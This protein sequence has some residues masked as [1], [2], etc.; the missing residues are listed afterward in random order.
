MQDFVHH[1]ND[2]AFL[3]LL[4]TQFALVGLVDIVASVVGH[5]DN[6]VGCIG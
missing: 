5:T 4:V 1:L 3:A 6:V 2:T